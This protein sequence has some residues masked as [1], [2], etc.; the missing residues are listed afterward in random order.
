MRN[1]KRV[2]LI[3][4]GAQ[5]LGRYLAE[6]LFKLGHSIIILDIRSFERIP[7]SYGALMQDYYEVDLSDLMAAENIL[8]I[9]IQK[10]KGIDVLINNASIRLFKNYLDFSDSEIER[11][12]NV[13][14]KTPIL[15]MKKLFPIMKKNGYG[16][17]INISSKSGFSGYSS[18][19]MYC[20]TK[21]ALIKFSEA[22]GRELNVHNDNV[23]VNVICP[24]SFRTI[25]GEKLKGYDRIINIITK[26]VDSIMISYRNA[27]V[28]PILLKGKKYIK[29]VR[30]LKNIF[31]GL[32]K[33]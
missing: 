7:D 22:F 27:E 18:G 8:N 20:S 32:V 33:Y 14:F 13:N 1:K 3:T 9:I 29:I 19:S 26:V 6:H 21:G 25:G 12:I 24:D 28:I 16:R 17:I 11:Y 23:T 4:G 30:E 31:F 2:I 15:L 10:Y 5:G